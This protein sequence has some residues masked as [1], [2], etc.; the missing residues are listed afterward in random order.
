MTSGKALS[1]LR[2]EA[3]PFLGNIY[4]LIL[5]FLLEDFYLLVAHNLFATMRKDIGFICS[6]FTFCFGKR[7]GWEAGA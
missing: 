5:G 2:V 6:I 4:F 7:L 3:Y 1:D